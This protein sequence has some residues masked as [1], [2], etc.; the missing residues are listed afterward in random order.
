MK[1]ITPNIGGLFTKA[2]IKLLIIAPVLL[3][4]NVDAWLVLAIIQ[5]DDMGISFAEAQSRRCLLQALHF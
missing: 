2:L 3:S 5:L 4:L 1:H